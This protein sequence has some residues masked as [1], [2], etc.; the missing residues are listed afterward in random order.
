MPGKIFHHDRFAAH[1]ANNINSHLAPV[2]LLALGHNAEP[3]VHGLRDMDQLM[4]DRFSGITDTGRRRDCH[5][6]HGRCLRAKAG[7]LRA[8]H[9]PRHRN[10][11]LLARYID[12]DTQGFALPEREQPSGDII[13]RHRKE[14]GL[15]RNRVN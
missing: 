14:L 10:P 15:T 3:A 13:H 7:T 8:Q 4:R 5:F 12:H 1:P 6:E 9:G 2:D 11:H